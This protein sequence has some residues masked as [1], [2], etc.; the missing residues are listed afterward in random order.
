MNTKNNYPLSYMVCLI[1]TGIGIG[2]LIGLSVS[3]VVSIVITSI[4]GSVVALIA[5][6][7]G[8][9]KKGS[10]DNAGQWQVNPI[11]LAMLMIGL[12][13][14]S[15]AGISAR[16][17]SWLGSDISA[18]IARWSKAGLTETG[19]GVTEEDL[20]LRLYHSQYPTDTQTIS[21][22]LPDVSTTSRT[23]LFAAVGPTECDSLY[24]SL[25]KSPDDFLDEIEKTEG[26]K[27]LPTIV[28]DSET[29]EKIIT[30]VICP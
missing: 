3:P 17:A 5:A 22:P 20:L 30:E 2:W 23:V 11:P 24:R 7:S 1:I 9:E 19:T 27:K 15:I 21:T 6:M 16:N 18:E 29:L 26:L 25:T 14:G 28:N 13:F 4:M 8:L 12:F 10:D